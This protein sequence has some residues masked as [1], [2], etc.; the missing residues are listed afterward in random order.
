MQIVLF[1][2][3]LNAVALSHSKLA[4]ADK[5]RNKRRAQR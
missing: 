4:S 2:V 5:S 1:I 3:S